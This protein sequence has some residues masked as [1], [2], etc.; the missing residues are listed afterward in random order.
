MSEKVLE[1]E[2]EEEAD[3]SDESESELELEPVL[4]ERLD[5]RC[6]DMLAMQEQKKI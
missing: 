3:L 2:L 1:K 4:R 6:L 5:L